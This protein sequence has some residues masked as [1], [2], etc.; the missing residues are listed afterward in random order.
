MLDYADMVAI[1]KFERRGSEDARRDVVPPARPQPR[2]VRC[3]S[4]EEMP[5][6]GTSAASFNDDGVT[7]LYQF[8]CAIVLGRQGTAESEPG[9]LGDTSTPRFRPALWACRF[10]LRRVR[11]LS[12]ISEARVGITYSVTERDRRSGSSAGSCRSWP[13]PLTLRSRELTSRPW[14]SSAVL[15]TL[16]THS[17]RS[18][19]SARWIP[20]SLKAA[21]E[22][23]WPQAVVESYSGD[24]QVVDQGP[25]QANCGPQL[26]QAPPC[27]A[28]RSRGS[29]CRSYS[30]TTAS[31]SASCGART[32][33]DY[34]PYHRWGFPVQAGW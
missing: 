20:T 10:P 32:C 3:Q 33:P 22:A 29:P 1:N 15:D 7:A 26:T 13:R 21:L 2:G 8:T 31:C 23:G 6:F 14:T 19:P 16:G 18:R 25:G 5:V 12:E 11:Y 4:W 24:E 28:T 17:A 30:A 9:V 34:F 27:R